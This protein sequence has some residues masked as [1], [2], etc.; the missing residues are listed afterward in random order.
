MIGDGESFD[1][2]IEEAA[3][4]ARQLLVIRRGDIQTRFDVGYGRAARIL[5]QL[6]SLGVLAELEL[7]PPT[8]VLS[9]DAPDAPVVRRAD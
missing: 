4:L 1:E 6:V 2:L 3:V 8:Y 5:D 9:P 7:T